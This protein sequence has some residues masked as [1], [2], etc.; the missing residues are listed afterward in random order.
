MKTTSKI[1]LVGGL[2]TGYVLGA[3]AGRERYDQIASA[4][5]SAWNSAPVQRQAEK[6]QG[7]VNRY[8]PSFV[9][10]GIGLLGKA[11]A[12]LVGLASRPASPP[13]PSGTVENPAR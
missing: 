12:G 7:L 5:R 8:V 9:E 11:L 1:A 4:V 13:Q 10:Q 6:V 3:R 2:V